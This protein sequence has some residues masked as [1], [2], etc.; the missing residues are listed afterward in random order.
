MKKCSF[1]DEMKGYLKE[2]GIEYIEIDIEKRQHK[3]EF[4]K[5]VEISKANSV[6]II[7]VGNKILVPERSFKTIREGYEITKKL[8][9]GN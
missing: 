6:P 9:R 4:D 2:G 3:A 7:L 8:L 1:C 5:L